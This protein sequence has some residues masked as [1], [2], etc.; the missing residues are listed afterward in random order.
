MPLSNIAAGLAKF[1]IICGL[2]MLAAPW[3]TGQA[4]SGSVTGHISCGGGSVGI[5]IDIDGER[6]AATAESVSKLFE[7]FPEPRK[8]VDSGVTC[9][10]SGARKNPP[11]FAASGDHFGRTT[12]RRRV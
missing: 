4:A 8:K 11:D 5:S 1:A 2:V 7:E 12:Y 3:Q 6:G 10:D 9:D